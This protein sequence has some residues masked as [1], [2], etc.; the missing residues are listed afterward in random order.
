MEILLEFHSAREFASV[1]LHAARRARGDTVTAVV[2]NF[3]LE[4][5]NYLGKSIR[6]AAAAAT[7]QPSS[8]LGPYN[9]TVDLKK[10]VGRFVQIQLDFTG[11]WLLLSEVAFQSGTHPSLPE[12]S[13]PFDV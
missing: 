3:A 11:E 6:S 12:A 9:V 4:S 1:T 13:I 7:G 2:V 5:G 8:D 10:R